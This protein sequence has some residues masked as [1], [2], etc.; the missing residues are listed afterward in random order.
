MN[1]IERSITS[2]FIQSASYL[3]AT[4]Y[5]AKVSNIADVHIIDYSK[6]SYET[7]DFQ[8]EYF[9]P[10]T[11]IDLLA[12]TQELGADMPSIFNLFHGTGKN[13]EIQT[14]MATVEDTFSYWYTAPVQWCKLPNP[15]DSEIIVHK[16][17]SA[18]DVDYVNQSLK[19]SERPMPTEGFDDPHISRFYV[20]LDEKVV[21]WSQMI[22][23]V[24]PKTAYVGEMFTL[25]EY[26]KRGIAKSLLGR[27][28]TEADLLGCKHVVLVP[29]QMAA[30]FY[31]QYGYESIVEF[32]V[33]HHS[34]KDG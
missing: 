12:I 17:S 22:V 21:A 1:E 7:E 14:K 4:I 26:R 28:H 30:N 20:V 11:S 9:V 29:S 6:S 3:F 24:V 32:S 15:L 19:T 31:T 33:F 25:P 8:L 27:I 10:N 23:N 18:A 5:E 13:V 2:C 16:V 34:S